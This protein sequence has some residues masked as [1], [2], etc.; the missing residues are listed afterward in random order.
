MPVVAV[1]LVLGLVTPAAAGPTRVITLP[2]AISAE[3][4]TAGRGNT[5]YAGDLLGGDIFRG[6]IRRGTAELFI[7][8]PAG[9]ETV[10]MDLDQHHDLL[11]VAGGP[12]Q[13]GGP[14]KAYVYSTRTRALVASYVLGDPGTSLVN[15]VTVTPYGAWFTDSLQPKLYFVPLAFGVPGPVRTL[16]LT[17]PAAGDPGTFFINDITSTP[18]GRTLLVAPGGT[19]CT[20]DPATGASTLVAGVHIPG[21]DGLVLDGRRLW[22]VQFDNQVSRWLLRDDLSHG[23]PDGV[24]TNPRF[25]APVTAAKFGNRLAVVNSHLDTGLP[26]TNPTYEVV[27]VNA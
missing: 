20:I 10:G 21:A 13:T 15:G 2:G 11:F 18:S 23:T 14:G 9:T 8:V 22:A 7:D 5:F 17:G 4:I 27:V 19:L 1:S 16:E 3:G 26:P 12:I 24:I 25:A 6:D